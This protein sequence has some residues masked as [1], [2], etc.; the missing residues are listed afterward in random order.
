MKQSNV[1]KSMEINVAFLYYLYFGSTESKIGR[2][3]KTILK[4]RIFDEV[5]GF[6]VAAA[7][8]SWATRIEAID[9]FADS[10]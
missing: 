1:Q 3:T 7:D 8:H 2:K 6:V 10:L 4:L 5:N 9:C